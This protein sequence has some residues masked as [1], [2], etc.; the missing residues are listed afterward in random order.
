MRE[1]TRARIS[2]KQRS[3]FGGQNFITREGVSLRRARYDEILQFL[4]ELIIGLRGCLFPMLSPPF[5]SL[6]RDL[7]PI[8][9]RLIFFLFPSGFDYSF[10]GIAERK[11]EEP[12]A[13]VLPASVML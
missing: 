5:S 11:P 10:L 7:G 13:H 6:A 4:W 1:L 2:L 3:T 12:E 9:S 8:S